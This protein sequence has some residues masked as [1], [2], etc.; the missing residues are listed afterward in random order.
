[1]YFESS[2]NQKAEPKNKNGSHDIGIFQI[3]STHLH[4]AKKM[5]L[6]LYDIDDNATFAIYLIKL[7]PDLRDWNAS[8]H[9]WKI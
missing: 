8:K 3:N 1:M 9:N 5:G 6:N 4:T 2:Y 7:H